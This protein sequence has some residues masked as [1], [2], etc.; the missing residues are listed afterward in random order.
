MKLAFSTAGFPIEPCE[1]MLL[2]IMNSLSPLP[3]KNKTD[4]CQQY[5]P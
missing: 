5:Y 4:F 2:M 1:T 3:H